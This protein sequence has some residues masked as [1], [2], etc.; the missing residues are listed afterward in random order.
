MERVHIVGVSPRTGT[1]LLFEAMRACFAIDASEEH[2]VNH[3]KHRRGP[4]IYLT[5]NPADIVS[6]GPR[7]AVDR[8][9]HVVAMLRDPRDIIVSRHRI[10]PT[11]YY[12]PLRFWKFGT[13]ILSRLRQNARFVLLRYEDLVRDPDGI[14][15]FL[16][17]KMKFLRKIAPFRGFHKIASPSGKSL[18]ALGSLRPF[19][20]TSVGVWRNHLP[21]VAGQI[22]MYGPITKEL[23]EL[24]YEVDADW[25]DLLRHIKPDLSPD[26]FNE[27][28]GRPL[29]KYRLHGYTDAAVIATARLL[30]IPLV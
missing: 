26:H 12:A 17:Q 2:E 27:A 16:I 24:G 14:Q 18:T 7:L 28:R 9:F 13:A 25:L 30:R 23:I 10:H 21:R 3:W 11:V 29:W 8:H 5:K 15:N 1:T 20:A 4:D 6:V 19:D 22:A